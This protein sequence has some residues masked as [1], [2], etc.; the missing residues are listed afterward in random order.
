MSGAIKVTIE[1]IILVV[2][3]VLGTLMAALAAEVIGRAVGA[4][5]WFLRRVNR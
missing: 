1:L 3:A 5:R 2:L 4:I